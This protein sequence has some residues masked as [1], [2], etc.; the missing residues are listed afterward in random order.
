MNKAIPMTYLQ[1]KSKSEK[2]ISIKCLQNYKEAIQIVNLL[3]EDMLLIQW[4]PMHQV[5]SKKVALLTNT[6]LTNTVTNPV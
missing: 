6:H 1:W 5:F 4:Q 2:S 3:K